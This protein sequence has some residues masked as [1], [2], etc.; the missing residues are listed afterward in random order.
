M[1]LN[2]AVSFSSIPYIDPK[3]R[4]VGVSKLRELNA[5]K[6]KEL[7]QD[8]EQTLVI[9]DNDQPLAV[10]LSY[11]KF[12]IMQWPPCPSVQR[13]KGMKKGVE[14]I[15]QILMRPFFCSFLKLLAKMATRMTHMRYLR[16][17]L[18]RGS[19]TISSPN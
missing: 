7:G 12:L 10:L 6:L 4:H 18:C 17:W 14:A 16:G 13:Y 3:V 11:E 2:T 5:T 1:V 19:S 9:Q 8:N 15:Q